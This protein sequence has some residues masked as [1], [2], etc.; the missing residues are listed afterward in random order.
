MRHIRGLREIQTHGT[1]AREGRLVSVARDWHR[2]G[3]NKTNRSPEN[4]SWDGIVSPVMFKKSAAAR[5]PSRCLFQDPELEKKIRA[6]QIEQVQDSIVEME[7]FASEGVSGV[8][9]ELQR[10]KAKLS[11]L[12]SG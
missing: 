7:M 1:L 3:R 11:Q 2:V 8:I 5:R 4:E 12:E 6:M 10:L 9:A